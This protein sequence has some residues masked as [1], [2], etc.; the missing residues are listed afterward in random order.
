MTGDGGGFRHAGGRALRSPL[1]SHLE[2]C[3]DGVRLEEPVGPTGTW[4]L[5]DPRIGE[6]AE[7]PT[8][9][10][11]YTLEWVGQDVA[12]C[13][14]GSESF[15]EAES[16]FT[17]IIA[18]D[19]A[20]DEL[21]IV[22][23]TPKKR[24]R[25]FDYIELMTDHRNLTVTL[26]VGPT[27]A[28]Q[29]IDAVLLRVTRHSGALVYWA[30]VSIYTM[31]NLKAHQ[32]TP[33]KWVWKSKKQWVAL[34]KDMGLL[35]QVLDSSRAILEDGV[36]PDQAF[37][38][39][40]AIS[41]AALLIMLARWRLDNPRAGGLRSEDSRAAATT[42]LHS[43]VGGIGSLHA[44]TLNLCLDP[45]RYKNTWPSPPVHPDV[46]LAARGGHISLDEWRA[47]A[48][49]PGCCFEASQLL[50]ECGLELCRDIPVASLLEKLVSLKKP[51]TYLIAQVAMQVA[52]WVDSTLFKV[53]EGKAPGGHDGSYAKYPR[54][55]DFIDKP[56]LMNAFLWRHVQGSVKESRDATCLS[57]AS[58]SGHCGMKLDCGF[59]VHQTGRVS[60]AAPQ[61]SHCVP[62]RFSEN[63]PD[64]VCVWVK[65]RDPA[66]DRAPVPKGR[67]GLRNRQWSSLSSR[68]ILWHSSVMLVALGSSGAESFGSARSLSPLW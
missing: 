47:L 58:D 50:K 37:L 5:V 14:T 51:P 45:A 31:L 15:L 28:R 54:V 21:K 20:S 26:I 38:P 65:W 3:F 42:L 22:C 41:T 60:I 64:L 35:D 25:I 44:G 55:N 34:L 43:V 6:R 66:Y 49:R 63:P 1:P 56:D 18:R 53:A 57:L 24:W 33:S 2:P 48:A 46:S 62:V 27:R 10:G 17:K 59:F 30:A 29:N 32:N 68:P 67:L 11:A 12:V 8:P 9:S 23:W 4:A 7:L 16:V 13:D 39:F 19:S 36:R 52:R 40:T 61:A